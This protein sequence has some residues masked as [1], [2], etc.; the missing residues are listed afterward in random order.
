[1][2]TGVMESNAFGA[3]FSYCELCCFTV[4]EVVKIAMRCGFDADLLFMRMRGVRRVT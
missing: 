1:V 3:L 4:C 2:L